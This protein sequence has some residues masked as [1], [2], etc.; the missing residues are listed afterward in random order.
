MAICLFCRR[1]TQSQNVS[2]S[3]PLPGFGK[4]YEMNP[5]RPDPG[6]RGKMNL[7]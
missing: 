4:S 7:F 3:D 6:Q 5:S 1:L 2:N